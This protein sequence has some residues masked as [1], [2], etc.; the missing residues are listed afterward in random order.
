MIFR[1]TH[2]FKDFLR[3]N[4]RTLERQSREAGLWVHSVPCHPPSCLLG[5][6]GLPHLG[7]SSLW[8]TSDSAAWCGGRSAGLCGTRPELDVWAFMHQDA[9][10]CYLSL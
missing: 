4:E 2:T 7:R 6:Q 9:L 10:E 5:R 1:N 3:T 8:Q